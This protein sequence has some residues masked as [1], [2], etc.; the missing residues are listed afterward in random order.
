[1]DIRGCGLQLLFHNYSL[2]APQMPG[3]APGPGTQ[4]GCNCVMIEGPT[5]AMAGED[6]LC[7]SV[8]NITCICLGVFKISPKHP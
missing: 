4:R 1:M 8:K 3:T 5:I 2:N 6:F 7:D